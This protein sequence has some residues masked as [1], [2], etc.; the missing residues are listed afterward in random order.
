MNRDALRS[1][2]AAGSP[3]PAQPAVGWV[4]SIIR[5]GSSVTAYAAASPF[6]ATVADEVFTWV[7]TGPMYRYPP[8]QRRL[9]RAFAR[10]RYDLD[11]EVVALANRL[12]TA[13]A[14]PVRF[15]V[16]KHPHLDFT[17]ERF[18]SA[19]PDHGAVWLIRNP[20]HRVESILARGLTASMRPAF[21]LEHF[22][23][24]ARRWLAR[25]EPQRLRFDQLRTDAHGYFAAVYR[26][27]GWPDDGTRAQQ[28]ARYAAAHYHRSCKELDQLDPARPLAE[29]CTRLTPQIIDTY[30]SDPFVVDLMQQLGWSTR[31][32]DYLPPPP[33]HAR[34]AT[35]ASRSHSP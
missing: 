7:R 33:P 8:V 26:A 12:F 1:L 30:L 14:Q 28:A 19:F 4:F 5:S 29:Q 11:A 22:K 34:P 10:A 31:P 25:P 16:C 21:D 18:E 2:P 32:D 20:L 9:V 15:V 6:L 24:F 3:Q 27:W 35:T 13:L 17:P 23:A